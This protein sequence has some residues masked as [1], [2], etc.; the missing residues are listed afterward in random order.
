MAT[1][2][3][4]GPPLSCMPPSM[5]P[6][7]ISMRPPMPTPYGKAAIHQNHGLFTVGETVDAAA[8]WFLA[9]ER[10]CQAQLLAEAVGSPK[11]IRPEW[12]NF[13]RENTASAQ[14]GWLNF[15]SFWEEISQSDPELFN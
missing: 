1:G 5:K 4:I 14:A 10:C 6:G 12:A 9:M 13:T 11:Q 15:Q 2:P 8:Y 3:S 7:R